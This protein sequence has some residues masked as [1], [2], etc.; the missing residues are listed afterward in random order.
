MR[1]ILDRSLLAAYL[2]AGAATAS[3]D[4]GFSPIVA[5]PDPDAHRAELALVPVGDLA[6]WEGSHLLHPEVGLVMTGRAA[7]ALIS[8]VRPDEL[9]TPTVWL[10][11]T[12]ITA[13]LLAR[14]VFERYYGTPVGRWTTTGEGATAVIVE[15]ED[16]LRPPEGGVSNDLGRAWFILNGL[17]LA[18]HALLVPEGADVEAVAAVAEW[19]R[20]RG[21]LGRE[22]RR[23]V[24]DDLVQRTGATAEEV[25]TFLQSVRHELTGNDLETVRLLFQLAHDPELPPPALRLY[26]GAETDRRIDG[27]TDR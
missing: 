14:A 2:I 19:I 12:S 18:T 13:Y 17:P 9:E 10:R 20:S 8:P 4:L 23:A 3:P 7:M 21:D 26:E 27:Q 6:A 15:G 5:S 25:V 24:R 22:A 11:E 1:L 16:A